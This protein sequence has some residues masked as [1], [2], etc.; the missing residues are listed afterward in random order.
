MS[1][2]Y[3]ASAGTSAGAG[4]GAGAPSQLLR[5]RA[6]TNYS[7]ITS[8]M[9]DPEL[10]E[11]TDIL[12]TTSLFFDV[13]AASLKGGGLR[14]RRVIIDE[15][16]AIMGVLRTR[17]PADM[18]WLVSGTLLSSLPSAH[19]TA[20]GSAAA[21]VVCIGGSSAYEVYRH[22]LEMNECK[23]SDDF[24][25]A[26][27]QLD[28]PAVLV[29]EL[30]SDY[31]DGLMV[32][33]LTETQLAAANGMDFSSKAL[34]LQHTTHGATSDLGICTVCF[35]KHGSDVPCSN[36]SSMATAH[37]APITTS[38]RR[39]KALVL[40]ELLSEVMADPGSH[41]LVFSLYTGILQMCQAFLDR[42]GVHRQ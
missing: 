34:G 29:H 37:A 36:S 4:A 6:L 13:V 30:Y 19:A 31:V 26:M 22:T 12:L 25:D 7:D 39:D 10:L 21:A 28:E 24:L 38:H 16:D 33:V 18:T 35:N 9:F 3:E 5:W 14:V 1:R 17:V 2:I 20:G 11:T 40:R 27:I 23:C 42:L 8:I 41:V 32:P 15:V